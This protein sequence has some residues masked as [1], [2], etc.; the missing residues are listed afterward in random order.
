MSSDGWSHDE[1]D[2]H[3]AQ[4]AAL[5]K[6]VGMGALDL[7]EA[8]VPAEVIASIAAHKLVRAAEA[9][10]RAMAPSRGETIAS[11]EVGPGGKLTR[12]PV[13]QPAPTRS[14]R[15]RPVGPAALDA[16][17]PADA[18]PTV[19]PYRE[20]RDA[21]EARVAFGVAKYGTELH[22]HNGRDAIQ[23]ALEE[24][25]DGMQYATQAAMEARDEGA[26]D[27][28]Y[29]AEDARRMFVAAARSL[30]WAERARARG[31]R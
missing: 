7:A 15:S 13:G 1:S 16:L 29:W 21:L 2:H 28:A 11:W 25:L 17:C 14:E 12:V 9:E 30:L 5:G 3:K 31:G 20:V 6:A 19:N 23:D 24:A 10:L 22:T 26:H 4:V 18:D 8:G 27:A